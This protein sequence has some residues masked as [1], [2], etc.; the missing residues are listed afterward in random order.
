MRIQ[1][2]G[3]EGV[4]WTE[5]PSH[6]ASHFSG[7]LHVEIE[8][9]KV[10][11][12]VGVRRERLRGGVSYSRDKLLQIRVGH[13]GDRAFPEVVVVQAEDAGIGSK[14]QF[15]SAMAPGEIVVD[16][17]AGGAPALNPG[18]VK[19][20][21]GSE[22]VRSAALQHDRK[23]RQCLLQITWPK[24]AFVPGECGIEVVHQVLGE[25]VRVSRSK[26]VERLRRKRVEHRVDG[27]RPRGW[28]SGVGLKTKPSR[29]FLVDVVV[30]ADGL[31]LFVVVAGVRNTLSIGGSRPGREMTTEYT[32][33]GAS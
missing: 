29:V 7:V 26:R 1:R 12:L 3:V 24:Q 6:F 18:V 21:D 22:R 20:S 28:Q 2:I 11:R 16:E 19:S 13:R 17:K 25:D 27:V 23:S 33:G 30:D 9:E 32:S 10:K 4:A 5:R 31:H 14:S 15:V 8:I